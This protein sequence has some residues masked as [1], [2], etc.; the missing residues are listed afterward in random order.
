MLLS[1]LKHQHNSDDCSCVFSINRTVN[2]RRTLVACEEGTHSAEFISLSE[3]C[4]TLRTSGFLTLQILYRMV[5]QR[6]MIGLMS[7]FI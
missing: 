6:K 2:K 3:F 7:V 4:G 1:L 5:H